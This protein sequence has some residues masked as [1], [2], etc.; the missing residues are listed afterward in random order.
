MDLQL[1]QVTPSPHPEEKEREL[2]SLANSK[3][4]LL[5]VHKL[6]KPAGFQEYSWPQIIHENSYKWAKRCVI[7]QQ[8]EEHIG[9]DYRRGYPP[10]K[11][12]TISWLCRL[13][14][15]S[16]AKFLLKMEDD[17]VK[18]QSQQIGRILCCR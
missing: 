3:I 7:L 1:W 17:T 14:Q 5:K 16:I 15:A 13:K 4:S 6:H 11:P 2:D 10:I 8:K 12:V 9:K 18:S